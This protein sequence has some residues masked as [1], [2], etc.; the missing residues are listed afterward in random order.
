M[1]HL[2]GYKGSEEDWCQDYA[3]GDDGVCVVP[4]Q[5]EGFEEGN[6]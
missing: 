6:F 3:Q 2:S 4:P 5:R 1:W